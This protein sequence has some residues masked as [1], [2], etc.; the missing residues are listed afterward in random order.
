M[1]EFGSQ[2]CGQ[3][4]NP[5]PGII[6][7]SILLVVLV[8]VLRVFLLVLQFYSLHKSQHFPN[9]KQWTDNYS[10]KVPLIIFILYIIFTSIL[11]ITL[12]VL[13]QEHTIFCILYCTSVLKKASYLGLKLGEYHTSGFSQQLWFS[14]DHDCQS[15]IFSRTDLNCCSSL[16]HDITTNLTLAVIS[17]GI[18]IGLFVAAFFQWDTENLNLKNF[19]K[20]QSIIKILS[21]QALQPISSADCEY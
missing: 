8:F 3:D 12:H 5:S 14:S 10:I 6:S 18:F 15:L 21:Q 4:S 17:K 13:A 11:L 16:S 9:S 7:G 19:N 2:Q 20:K 1:R